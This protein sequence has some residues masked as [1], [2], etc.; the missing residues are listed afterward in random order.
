M[1]IQKEVLDKKWELDQLAC[2]AIY[3]RGLVD[4][5]QDLNVDEL[6]K[7]AYQGES[8]VC[9]VDER[10]DGNVHVAGSL[11][12]L[13]LDEAKEIVT[14]HKIIGITSHAG[15][16]AMGIYY[17]QTH[18]LGETIS[19]KELDTFAIEETKKLAENLGIAYSGHIL[20]EE[21]HGL[22]SLHNARAVYY[23]ATPYFNANQVNNLPSGFCVS[24]SILSKKQALDD[25]HLCITI[26]FG[27]HGF[28]SLFTDENPLLIIGIAPEES[29]KNTETELSGLQEE[30]GNRIRIEMLAV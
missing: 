17:N 28:G 14:K 10:V 16:G 3:Q 6:Q 26:A 30:Y 23:H 25:V 29:L 8:I 20:E 11:I 27:D 18:T 13:P 22:I 7:A 24:R 21:M 9:C 15:C 12:L 2:E 4:H 5:S 1:A 19:Q